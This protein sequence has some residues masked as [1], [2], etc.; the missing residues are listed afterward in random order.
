MVK[1][2]DYEILDYALYKNTGQIIDNAKQQISVEW[3]IN[4]K[5]ERTKNVNAVKVMNITTLHQPLFQGVEQ[6]TTKS[7]ILDSI[8]QT[9]MLD[10][11]MIVR[12][13]V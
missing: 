5:K 8:S 13:A 7:M 1:V 12:V 3:T 2:V 11:C 6:T 10:P 4:N 9:V